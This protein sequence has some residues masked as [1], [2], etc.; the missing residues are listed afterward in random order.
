LGRK[1]KKFRREKTNW[2]VY[3]LY[4]I[5]TEGEK[6]EPH[7]FKSLFRRKNIRMEILPTRRGQSS[8]EQ[9]LK[10]LDNYRRKFDSSPNKMWL[11]IDRDCE[12]FSKEQLS[13]IAQ[14]C[15][16]KGYNLALS[17][18]CFELWL[19]LHQEK[20]KQPLTAAACKKE[21]K[22]LIPDFTKAKYDVAKLGKNI[23]LAVA[24]AKKLDNGDPLQDPP[25]TKVYKLVEKLNDEREKLARQNRNQ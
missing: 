19:L 24:H 10:R 6:T 14:K 13:Q 25:S 22:K 23:D 12:N 21:L 17:N 15:D 3:P 4:V 18:P 20:P 7:Y 8:A 2:S 5:A 9:V 11:V 1:Q 16:A